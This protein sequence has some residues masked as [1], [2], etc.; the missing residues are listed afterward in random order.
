MILQAD[1][2]GKRAIISGSWVMSLKHLEDQGLA[3]DFDPFEL[4]VPQ[5]RDGGVDLVVTGNDGLRRNNEAKSSMPQKWSGDADSAIAVGA[6]DYN[7]GRA[8]FSL[9]VYSNEE[10]VPNHKFPDIY[11]LGTDVL[12]PQW[13]DGHRSWGRE[14]G[15]SHATAITSGLLTILIARQDHWALGVPLQLVVEG[16]KGNRWWADDRLAEYDP[17]DEEDMDIPSPGS[18]PDDELYFAPPAATTWEMA[19]AADGA[20][21]MGP[22]DRP[23]AYFFPKPKDKLFQLDAYTF[24]QLDGHLIDDT[25]QVLFCRGARLPRPIA[26]GLG[27]RGAV[28]PVVP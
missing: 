20:V 6:C 23:Q 12:A 11:N 2:G 16:K 9:F 1:N 21:P 17:D 22:E 4:L 28:S 15:S 14:H 5:L 13:A 8:L 19:C 27:R 26:E 18:V 7:S 3:T 24:D 10:Q 25:P